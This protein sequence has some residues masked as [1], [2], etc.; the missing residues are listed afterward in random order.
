[1]K[2]LAKFFVLVTFVAIAAMW[3][4]PTQKAEAVAYC[5]TGFFSGNRSCTNNP[6]SVTVND[7]LEGRSWCSGPP[8]GP[9]GT[10]LKAAQYSSKARFI[11]HIESLLTT[12]TKTDKTGAAFIINTMAP[13][14][15]GANDRTPSA[16]FL[17]C[18][19]DAVNNADVTMRVRTLSFNATTYYSPATN[20]DFVAN[21]A[22]G[23]RQVLNFSWPGNA[24]GYSIE[25]A[26]GNPAGSLP[27]L[28]VNSWNLNATSQ[29]INVSTGAKSPLGG[30]TYA[31]RGQTIEFQ[32]VVTNAGPGPSDKYNTVEVYTN[33]ASAKGNTACATNPPAP[34][35]VCVPSNGR[36]TGNAALA[37]GASKTFLVSRFAI[38]ATAVD[39]QVYCQLIGFA[40]PTSRI[41]TTEYSYR[42]CV[43]VRVAATTWNLAG[44]SR[45]ISGS[46]TGAPGATITVPAGSTFHF[47]HT[48]SNS[49]ASS[50]ASTTITYNTAGTSVIPVQ[51]S[52]HA[53]LAIGA[54]FAV[55]SNSYKI[56]AGTAAGTTYC[57]NITFSPSSSANSG[58]T[59]PAQA[60]VLVGVPVPTCT[61]T[62]SSSPGRIQ[63]GDV[64][65]ITL[66]FNK[67]T[68]AQKV[69]Y[70]IDTL[71][72]SKTVDIGANVSSITLPDI[73]VPNSAADYA[74]TWSVT[75][76][77]GNCSG[78]V[79]VVGMPYFGVYG[80]GVRAGG[81]FGG[82]CS[83]GGVLGAWR[84][85]GGSNNYGAGAELNAIALAAITGF[86]SSNAP[87]NTNPVRLTFANPAPVTNI[88]SPS[89]GGRYG[90]TYCLPSPSKPSSGVT[91]LT[92]DTSFSPSSKNGAYEKTGNIT[93][94]GGTI[95]V[96]QNTSLFVKGD[97]YIADNILYA[98]G[99]TARSDVPSFVLVVTGNIIVDSDVTNLSGVY[100]AK[101]NGANGGNIYTCGSA[102]GV[103]TQDVLYA[104]NKQL[105]VHGSFVAKRV[106][107]L[108]TLGTLKNDANHSNG[109]CSNSG[110]ITSAKPTCAAEV[111]EFSPELYLANPKVQPPSN[112]A[113][114]YDS[115]ITLPPIL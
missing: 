82:T 34:S 83:G 7:V 58:S 26:C 33:A 48:I 16:A 20:D 18:W 55:T 59:K 92:S 79:S 108:R 72:A 107:L 105:V 102:A 99:W 17:D 14:A 13:A 61:G 84:N 54:R 4:V 35:V 53:G 106:H 2:Y 63:P 85:Y 52:T 77:A 30:T 49:A 86:A 27:P 111:F 60:C 115:I 56:P 31:D 94:N 39:G 66:S 103:A 37:K 98:S 40:P 88:D 9:C 76:L 32:H 3:A 10:A 104:C 47:E 91:D 11:A 51:S 89:L 57:Q 95:G 68:A 90:S 12:G 46:T 36:Q 43:V 71:A 93:L 101:P 15:C 19:E 42:A 75:G 24:T 70:S 65:S 110:G 45:A 69:T 97:V 100:V 1:M 62:V 38:P 114:R 25:L 81:D 29:A 74:A 109:G 21:Y 73:T 80:A 8:A 112:G 44:E 67:T 41:G 87:S 50:G 64:A 113:L 6:P 78:T 23:S 28:P 96:G 22:V 5:G